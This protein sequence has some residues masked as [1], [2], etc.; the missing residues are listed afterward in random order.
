MFVSAESSTTCSE[1]LGNADF[2]G[3]LQN[4]GE[5]PVGVLR[6]SNKALLSRLISH[7]AN[8][9]LNCVKLT[10]DEAKDLV[11]AIL[12]T[13]KLSSRHLTLFIDT[14][15][16]VKT[17]SV[18]PENLEEFVRQDLLLVLKSLLACAGSSVKPTLTEIVQILEQ[19]MQ[20]DVKPDSMLFTEPQ[21]P[22]PG[23]QLTA[24]QGIACM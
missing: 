1:L 24:L 6:I 12:E 16:L 2:L 23:Q 17:F 4:V 10:S 5:S 9:P 15:L 21:R 20:R 7:G 8:I 18:N 11:S 19:H 14:A 13:N 22:L 3:V